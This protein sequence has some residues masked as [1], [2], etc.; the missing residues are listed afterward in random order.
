M[1]LMMKTI[2]AYAFYPKQNKIALRDTA[3]KEE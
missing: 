1:E 2:Q 3:K